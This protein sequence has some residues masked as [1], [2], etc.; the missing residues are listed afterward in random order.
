MTMCNDIT[1]W[2]FWGLLASR[3]LVF[4]IA[5]FDIHTF[6]KWTYAMF[7]INFKKNNDLTSENILA[8][9]VNDNAH[10]CLLRSWEWTSSKFVLSVCTIT[11]KRWLFSLKL[12]IC[13]YGTQYIA[14]F[15]YVIMYIAV[16]FLIV[17][18]THKIIFCK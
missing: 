9:F 18:Y 10:C 17:S 2:L 4:F 7:T 14:L 3:K 8:I 15:C 6:Y 1:Y 12:G 5:N 11:Q 16:Y 13:T